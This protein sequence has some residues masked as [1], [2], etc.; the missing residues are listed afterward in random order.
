[1]KRTLNDC[2][3]GYP[4]RRPVRTSSDHLPQQ[5]H[6]LLHPRLQ[7]EIAEIHLTFLLEQHAEV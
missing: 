2:G 1:M 3:L 7:Q 5:L 6:R 4:T